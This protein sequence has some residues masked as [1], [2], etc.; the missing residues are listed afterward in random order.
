VTQTTHPS[1]QL[2]RDFVDYHP[3][4]LSLMGRVAEATGGFW[5]ESIRPLQFYLISSAWLWR[6]ADVPGIAGS[7]RASG[8]N[9]R[10]SA[11]RHQRPGFAATAHALTAFPFEVSR[12][13]NCLSAT[14]L[15]RSPHRSA[16]HTGRRA[17]A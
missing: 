13:I 14:R 16:G 1:K 5:F 10:F 15:A 2:V 17:P 12:W 3:R 7:N 6:L 9:F 4:G 8:V 11:A